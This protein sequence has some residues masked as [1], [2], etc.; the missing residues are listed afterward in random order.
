M[1]F[2]ESLRHVKVRKFSLF[3]N[4]FNKVALDY[5]GCFKQYLYKIRK[6][7]LIN[8]QGAGAHLCHHTCIWIPFIV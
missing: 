4:N 2:M 3:I 8:T 1:L 7:F 5:M 6:E